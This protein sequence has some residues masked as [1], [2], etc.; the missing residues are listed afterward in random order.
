MKQIVGS[1]N[2]LNVTP[3]A[4]NT[5]RFG[6]NQSVPF[7]FNHGTPSTPHQQPWA[8]PPHFSPEKAFPTNMLH[9][10][11]DVDMSEVS[12][13]K[14]EDKKP[15]N[16]RVVAL[17]GMRRIYNKR[18]KSRDIRTGRR[19]VEEE[20]HNDADESDSDDE[21]DRAMSALTQNTS[22]HY[23]LNIPAPPPPQS[24]LPYVLLGFVI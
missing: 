6:A 16:G 22:N 15:E 5:S 10:P 2:D 8:P 23:T 17:G 12:P 11:N 4:Q 9:E 7:L 14:I 24:D 1:Y 18:Q 3:S 13:D 19:W 21:T 20:E